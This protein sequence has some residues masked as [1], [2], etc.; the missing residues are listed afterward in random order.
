[1]SSI[2]R[3]AAVGFGTA[4][5]YGAGAARSLL[6]ADSAKLT[7]YA[8]AP[9]VPSLNPGDHPGWSLLAWL[10]IHAIPFAG[11]V[12][13]CHIL[14]VA[15]GTAAA[16]LAALL[17]RDAGRPPEGALLLAAAHPIWW[18]AS[19]TETY[20]LAVALTLLVVWLARR[21]D[22][23]PAFLA[24]LAA[25]VA[26]TVHGLTVMLTGP[27]ALSVPRRRWLPVAVGGITGTVPVWLALWWNVPDPLTG[28]HA[29]GAG[30]WAWH[31]HAFV[32]AGRMGV[33][34]VLLVG[35][36]VFALGPLGLDAV[37]R[38]GR[39]GGSLHPC[40]RGGWV[41]LGLLAVLLAGY[42]PY[43]L[44]LMAG[45]LV[46]GLFLLLPP[47]MTARRAI[48][49]ILFQGVIYLTVPL[50]LTA[51]GFGDLGVRRLPYRDNATYFLWPWKAQVRGAARYVHE[52][53]GAAP[54]D[55]VILA[56]FN[57]GAPLVLAQRLENLR[58]DV[59]IVPTFIDEAA[60][61][62]DPAA[63]IAGRVRAAAPAPVV[64]AD[65]WEPYYRLLEL[66]SRFGLRLAR[67]GP[68][69]RVLPDGAQGPV[70]RTVRSAT[71]EGP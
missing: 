26:A 66:R 3:V 4:V 42:S 40:P 13:A 46:V 47:S 23:G 38:R 31:V 49:H 36:V 29:A 71:P 27:V 63:V 18:G 43:R 69:W 64:L 58:P 28:H 2:S 57:T 1:V 45:F 56:D 6:W 34:A 21:E 9:Y 62:R 33:G 61:A 19:V 44:H 11:P 50:A 10:W 5:V 60:A 20:A 67:C 55:A 68:G 22:A 12:V 54:E 15:A 51:A 30:S 37:V 14:S 16:V 35:L 8:M 70:S 17:L 59:G 7:L 41:A 52:L 24:G 48:L 53:L 32:E 39:G 25:G 65:G